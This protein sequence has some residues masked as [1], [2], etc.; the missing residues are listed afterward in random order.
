M[1]M[2]LTNGMEVESLVKAFR[3]NAYDHQRA[4]IRLLQS[5]SLK[6]F[7]QS[8]VLQF[9]EDIVKRVCPMIR[10]LLLPNHIRLQALFFPS[11]ILIF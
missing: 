10:Y 11:S 4:A 8:R 7:S 6:G 3:D 2:S 5:L 9:K 1:D